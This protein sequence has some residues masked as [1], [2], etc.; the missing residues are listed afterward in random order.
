MGRVSD[1]LAL[2]VAAA[3]L[4][5]L[6]GCAHGPVNAPLSEA[7]P[8]RQYRFEELE[9]GPGNTDSLFVCLSFSGGG[10]RAAALSYGVL[11]K[12]R[13]TQITWKGVTKSLLSEVDCISS[14]SGG[15]FTAAYYGLFGERIF[16]DYRATFLDADVEGELALAVANPA[17]WARLASP[18]FDR[19]DLA[20]ELFHERVFDRKT[21]RDLARAGR[22]PFVVI[23]ATNMVT[24]DRFEF[25]QDDL[26]LLG[27]D[28]GSFPVARAVAASAAVPVLLSPIT[29]R[30]HPRPPSAAPSP[31][32]VELRNGLQ[33][34]RTNREYYQWAKNRSAYADPERMPF[35]HLMDG[36]LADN[37]G[38]LAL[39]NAYRRGF[40]QRRVNDGRV[41]KLLVIVVNAHN[42]R[43]DSIS[44]SA[45][46]PGLPEVAYRT[47]TVAMD[48]HSLQSIQ[49]FKALLGERR[50]A[51]DVIRACRRRAQEQVACARKEYDCVPEHPRP[52]ECEEDEIVDF[53]AAID[54]HVADVDFEAIAGEG[55]RRYFLSLPTSFH[56]DA[57]AVDALIAAGA[58]L[59]DADPAYQQALAGLAP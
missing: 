45:S 53:A 42:E 51:Q 10:T 27:S 39:D 54:S 13:D 52:P 29:L 5:L 17:S 48:N 32:E 14:V 16:R 22:R 19:I 55:R 3:A 11:R 46:A 37:I 18:Y 56:L 49:L 36:G 7:A 28:L 26:D 30:N 34:F 20:A 24:G 31:A 38:I 1:A 47:A 4:G 15:S 6:T 35:V 59:L 2:G 41:E 8:G 33:S 58:E 40:L 43:E 57:A 23:N 12:L 44:R 21:F 50:A 9:P 25:T